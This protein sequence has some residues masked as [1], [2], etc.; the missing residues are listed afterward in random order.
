VVSILVVLAEFYG[1]GFLK[2][3]GTRV[4]ALQR[5]CPLFC[6]P[7]YTLC[8]VFCSQNFLLGEM[9]LSSGVGS[10]RE[11]VHASLTSFVVCKGSPYED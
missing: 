4:G 3:R 2:Q 8:M 5:D 1:S 11:T 6:L 10:S 9:N 7:T